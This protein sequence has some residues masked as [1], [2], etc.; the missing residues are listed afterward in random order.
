MEARLNPT[1][2][3]PGVV[4]ETRSWILKIQEGKQSI[5]IELTT[6]LHI[7][8]ADVLMYALQQWTR[9]REIGLNRFRETSLVVVNRAVAVG[10]QQLVKGTRPK[11][12]VSHKK[13]FSRRPMS[14]Q[15]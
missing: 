12:V 2:H 8:V 14:P 15:S 5:S 7:G 4:D 9:K 11:F 13:N 6:K 3:I 1:V 10:T